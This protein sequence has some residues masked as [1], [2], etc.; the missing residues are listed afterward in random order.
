MA[1]HD[2]DCEYD[3][4]DRGWVVYNMTKW[5]RKDLAVFYGQER[6]HEWAKNFI[7]LLEQRIKEDPSG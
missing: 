1:D 4:E 5:G 2:Y 7:R 6:A 3:E